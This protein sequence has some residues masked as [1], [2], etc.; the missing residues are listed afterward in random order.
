MG[1]RVP[2]LSGLPHLPGVPDLYVKRPSDWQNNN[3][4]RAPRI[5]LSLLHDCD[6]K[7]PNL[8]FYGGREHKSPTFDN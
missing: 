1:R 7:Q 2:H 5:S 8:A 3:L 6:V 4:P